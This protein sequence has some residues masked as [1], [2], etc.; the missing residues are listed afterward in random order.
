MFK[1]DKES[2]ISLLKILKQAFEINK[3]PFPWLKAISAAMC[4]GVPVSI[5]LVE[6]QLHLGLVGGI[7]GL[8]RSSIFFFRTH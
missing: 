2:P 3:K 1:N 6:G 8:C 7:G 4:V 5:G